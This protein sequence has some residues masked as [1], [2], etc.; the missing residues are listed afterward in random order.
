MELVVGAGDFERDDEEGEGEA[1][2]TSEKPSMRDMWVPRR[3]KPSLAI[4]S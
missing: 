1:K 4:R 2:T 3:R